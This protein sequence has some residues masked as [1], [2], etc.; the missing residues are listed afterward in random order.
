MRILE[1]HIKTKSKKISVSG[2]TSDNLKK[3]VL[4]RRSTII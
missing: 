3:T 4:K 1:S 2:E